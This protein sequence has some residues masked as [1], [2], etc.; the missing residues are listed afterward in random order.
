[1]LQIRDILEEMS[2]QKEVG[3]LPTKP[4]TQEM[5][6]AHIIRRSSKKVERF[7]VHCVRLPHPAVYIEWGYRVWK[8]SMSGGAGRAW[9]HCLR[10]PHPAVTL[11][12]A[13]EYE[14]SQCQEVP[15]VP[16]S[17]VFAFLTRL[18]HWMRLPSMKGL[19]VRRCRPCLSSLS[20]PS[21]PGCYI[22]WGYQV[23]KVSVS[24]AGFFHLVKYS[25]I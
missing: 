24:C 18:L 20:S 15:A 11:N 13:T 19:N 14:R 16:E 7:W 9:V 10:L 21:S 1:M 6:E 8:V 25:H 12:E 3:L 5:S 2:M 23:W 22:E 17:I 4:W